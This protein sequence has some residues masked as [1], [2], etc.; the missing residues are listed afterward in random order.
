MDKYSRSKELSVLPDD[1]KVL[2]GRIMARLRNMV[3]NGRRTPFYLLA[4]CAV[5]IN[6]TTIHKIFSCCHC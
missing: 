1:F 3:P 6:M 4:V 5:H 2:K